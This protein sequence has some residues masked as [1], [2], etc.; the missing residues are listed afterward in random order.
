MRLETLQC[1][2]ETPQCVVE[3]PQCDWRRRNAIGDAAMRC[4]DA[5]MRRL[6]SQNSITQMFYP[7]IMN[8]EL[9][10]MN[11]KSILAIHKHFQQ[12]FIEFLHLLKINFVVVVP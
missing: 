4:G 5:A 7:T 8:Y 6:Y 1:V 10:I 3:T 9:R 2:V 11:Y 12:R